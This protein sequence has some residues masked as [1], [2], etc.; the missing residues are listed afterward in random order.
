M[1]ASTYSKALFFVYINLLNL[2]LDKLVL[3]LGKLDTPLH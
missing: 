2:R 1:S 3:R